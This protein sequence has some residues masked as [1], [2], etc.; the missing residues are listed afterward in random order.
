MMAAGSD[1]PTKSAMSRVPMLQTLSIALLLSSG[2][3]AVASASVEVRL[4]PNATGSDWYQMALWLEDPQGRYAQTLYVTQDVG[5]KGLGNG[6]WRIFGITLRE[7]PGS[8]PVWAH[9]R[10][11]RYGK[12]YY[13][14]KS[15][16]LPDAV[17]G[18]TIKRAR[19]TRTF[20]LDAGVVR[21]RDDE[22]W[23]CLLEINVSRDGSPSMVF[24]AMPVPGHGPAP[25]RFV[26]YGEKE[27]RDGGLHEGEATPAGFVRG[28]SCRLSMGMQ[29]KGVP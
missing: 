12:S 22:S 11:V 19:F 28:A 25:F 2:S 13:P 6:F 17:S 20:D 18:A 26:G 10:G 24:R 29:A 1:L 8:L 16:P 27:G 21:R 14:P 7:V 23:P 5:Q 9:R 4:G 15:R 3:S